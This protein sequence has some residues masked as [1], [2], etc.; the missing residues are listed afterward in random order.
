MTVLQEEDMEE[1]CVFQ[2]PAP[3]EVRLCCDIVMVTARSHHARHHPLRQEA[4]QM[5][6][7]VK[8]L[9]SKPI[10]LYLNV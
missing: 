6:A 5:Q 4:A 10:Q 3:G 7:A 8:T 9:V 1:V 2:A